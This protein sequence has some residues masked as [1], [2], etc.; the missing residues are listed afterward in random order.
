MSLLAWSRRPECE[1]AGVGVMAQQVL[2]SVSSL[3]QAV[4]ATVEGSVRLS[5]ECGSASC[6]GLGVLPLFIRVN[7]GVTGCMNK[8]F[9]GSFYRLR[10]GV[11][12][13]MRRGESILKVQWLVLVGIEG[14]SRYS[15]QLVLIVGEFYF[16]MLVFERKVENSFPEFRVIHVTSLT[17]DSGRVGNVAGVFV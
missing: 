8:T 9:P 14:L 12:V 11:M 3:G 16:G 4:V 2:S 5:C 7:P 1:L 17:L 10:R 6:L 15:I 13:R